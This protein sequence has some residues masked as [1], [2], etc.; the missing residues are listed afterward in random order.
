MQ[1][2]LAS[3]KSSTHGPKKKS[4]SPMTTSQSLKLDLA[5]PGRVEIEIV[6]HDDD[7]YEKDESRKCI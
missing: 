4:P 2:R 1:S 7:A 5:S 3:Y 6:S